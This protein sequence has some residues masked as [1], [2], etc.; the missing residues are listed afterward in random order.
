MSLAENQRGELVESEVIPAL[1]KG[2]GKP[3]QGYAAIS[4]FDAY[5]HSV[6]AVS[7][8]LPAAGRRAT[9]FP[10]VSTETEQSGQVLSAYD[11]KPDGRRYAAC[12]DGVVGPVARWIGG[13]VY[14]VRERLAAMEEEA[15][16]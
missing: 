6:G 14:A 11:P 7:Q 15:A 16:A 3:G 1:S 12:G 9:S 8:T 2:G 13:R 5:N 10:M 4:V